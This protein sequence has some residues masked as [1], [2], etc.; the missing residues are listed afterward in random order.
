MR[1]GLFIDANIILDFFLKREPFAIAAFRL[2]ELLKK[3]SVIGY[4]SADIFTSLY[5]LIRKQSSHE[6]TLIILSE[7]EQLIKILPVTEKDI[8]FAL[9]TTLFRDFEDAVQYSVAKEH[10]L[11]YIITRDKKDYKNSD[12]PVVDAEEYVVSF[13]KK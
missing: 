6:R 9:K 5:Y 12:I 11:S 1:Q 13:Y 2:F 4:S 10:D 3:K 8:K 7:F